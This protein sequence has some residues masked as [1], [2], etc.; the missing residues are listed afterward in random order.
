MSAH[1]HR[2]ALSMSR[3][4]PAGPPSGVHLA[5][6]PVACP[7]LQTE[8][9]SWISPDSPSPRPH[10]G[11]SGRNQADCNTEHQ[12]SSFSVPLCVT[13]MRGHVTHPQIAWKD[14]LNRACS[15][16]VMSI[17]VRL[18]PSMLYALQQPVGRGASSA[19]CRSLHGRS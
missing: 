10:C 17:C 8:L 19:Q 16:D 5:F 9:P 4:C 11:V 18:H 6:S 14:L 7:A 2:K 15:L 12:K 1:G 3:Q 13:H